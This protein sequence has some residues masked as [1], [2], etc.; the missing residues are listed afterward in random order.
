M[1][2]RVYQLSASPG[3][4]PKYAV[5]QAE[6]TPL[7]LAGD[8]H[9]NM[10][11]H[12]GPRKA[13]LIITLEGLEELKAAGFAVS[14]GAL[15]ENITTEGLDRRTVRFGQRYRLGSDVIVEIT[16]LRTPCLNL[17]VYSKELGKAIYDA[18]CK[19]GDATSPRWGLGGFYARIV[20]PGPLRPG[21]PV[22]FLDQD[23]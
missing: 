5:P 11:V 18:Q 20:R 8:K 16:Q 9:R 22:I 15:G 3:G 19:A 14:P 10:Q 7:G 13:V 12:G 2:A 1:T 21:A 23:V 4:L 6:V 17:D